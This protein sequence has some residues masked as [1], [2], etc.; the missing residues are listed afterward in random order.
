[1]SD[2]H[3][4]SDVYVPE[5]SITRSGSDASSHRS[6]YHHGQPLLPPSQSLDA[7][8]SDDIAKHVMEISPNDGSDDV[9]LGSHIV[10]TFDKD[11][12]LVMINKL[13]EVSMMTSYSL[14]LHN[15]YKESLKRHQDI[16]C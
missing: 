12:K 6:P 14:Y 8:P 2:R 5:M 7:S 3:R 9:S 10:V 13:F 11:I 16:I 4:I 15:I 1:M